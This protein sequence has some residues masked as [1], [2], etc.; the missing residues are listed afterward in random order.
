M[1]KI[2]S[3]VLISLLA[4]VLVPQAF[5]AAQ[6]EFSADMVTR[7]GGQTFHGKIYS[8]KDKVRIETPAATIIN[9][10]DQKVSWVLMPEQQMYMEQPIDPMAAARMQAEVPGETERVSMGKEPVD[11]KPAEKFKVTYDAGR[12][13]ENIY[14][15]MGEGKFP[16]KTESLDGSWSVEF[17]N[18]IQGPQPAS[19]FEIPA[20][21]QKFSM[22]ALQQ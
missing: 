5:A 15:W 14:Q 17:Q 10:L 4:L 22:P 21:Y 9:R 6:A 11:G 13:P 7:E 8:A 3:C 16:L 1:R 2:I 18:L 12:G 19:L 20:D